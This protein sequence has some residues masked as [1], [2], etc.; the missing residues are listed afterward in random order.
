MPGFG[1]NKCSEIT[2]TASS[3][4]LRLLTPKELIIKKNIHLEQ[5]KQNHGSLIKE[6]RERYLN[7][8]QRP[9]GYHRSAA[10]WALKRRE[11]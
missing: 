6:I 2:L 8:S 5:R 10:R 1:T 9:Y 7:P 11:F 4:I 3:Y